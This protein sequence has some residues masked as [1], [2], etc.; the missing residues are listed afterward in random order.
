[1][2]SFDPSLTGMLEVEKTLPQRRAPPGTM[3]PQYCSALLPWKFTKSCVAWGHA[4][5]VPETRSDRQL[6]H[7]PVQTPSIPRSCSKGRSAPEQGSPA[8]YIITC[9]MA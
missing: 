7:R 5:P 1:M 8:L 9:E 6:A 4:V 2:P 3:V